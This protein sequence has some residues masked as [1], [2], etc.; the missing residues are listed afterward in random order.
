MKRKFKI[1]SLRKFKIRSVQNNIVA[2]CVDTG[3]LVF[4]RNV[5]RFLRLVR[6]VKQQLLICAVPAFEHHPDI[7]PAVKHAAVAM[8]LSQDGRKLVTSYL[9]LGNGKLESWVTFYNFGDVGQ[10]YVDNM[11]G[12]YSFEGIRIL[13]LFP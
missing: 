13:S 4:Q 10:N 5:Q 3:V 11:V 9:S 1:R 8:A 6:P 7:R 2:R 12:S